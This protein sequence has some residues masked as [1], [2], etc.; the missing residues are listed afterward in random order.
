MPRHTTITAPATSAERRWNSRETVRRTPHRFCSEQ[1]R[2]GASRTHTDALSGFDDKLAGESRHWNGFESHPPHT[3]PHA[4][5]GPTGETR[6]SSL[7]DIPRMATQSGSHTAPNWTCAGAAPS[8]STRRPHGRTVLRADAWTRCS[9]VAVRATRWKWTAPR[10]QHHRPTAD[11]E[12][13]DVAAGA[14]SPAAVTAVSRRRAV[15]STPKLGRPAPA[16]CHAMPPHAL[17]RDGPGSA[18]AAG[19]RVAT[20]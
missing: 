9:D 11:R 20:F 7:G 3:A 6:T 19:L 15:R 14:R 2:G 18:R 17:D 4:I 10:G 8:G 16:E 1:D 13:S 5:A 12:P